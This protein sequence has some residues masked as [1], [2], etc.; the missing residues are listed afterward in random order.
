MRL[1]SCLILLASLLLAAAC[2]SAPENPLAESLGRLGFS[3]AASNQEGEL[4][5]KKPLQ[6]LSLWVSLPQGWGRAPG[7]VMMIKAAGPGGALSAAT[8]QALTTRPEVG[9]LVEAASQGAYPP[10]AMAEIFK[11]AQEAAAQ[12]PRNGALMTSPKSG[13]SLRVPHTKGHLRLVLLARHK[14]P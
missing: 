12:P 9:Q 11:L 3:P 7:P 5:Y 10:K 14:K 6:G 13:Y 2:S 1:R 4:V 8:D